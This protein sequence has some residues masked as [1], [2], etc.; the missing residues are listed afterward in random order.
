MPHLIKDTKLP[1]SWEDGKLKE[2]NSPRLFIK[3]AFKLDLP[4]RGG[5]GYSSEDCVVIDKNDPSVNPSLPFDYIGT[6]YTYVEKRIYAELIVFRTRSDRYSDINWK[7]REQKLLNQNS[8]RFDVLK[9]TVSALRDEDW[10]YLKKDFENN[11]GY[12]NDPDALKK[13]LG[14]RSSRMCFYETEYW[15]E[16]S[17]CF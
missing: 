16:I 6:E 2:E 5:W 17:S 15:F 14:E 9:F 8:K 1:S 12:Q 4:I 13:H 3:N 10:D 11:N 7:I